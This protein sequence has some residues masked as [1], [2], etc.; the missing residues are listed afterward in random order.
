[1]LKLAKDADLHIDDE[2][3]KTIMELDGTLSKKKKK[4]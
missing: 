4:Q 1:M 3:E 2:D